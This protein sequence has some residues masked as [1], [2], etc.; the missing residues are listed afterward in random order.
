MVM[1]LWPRFL[2]HPVVTNALD[3]ETVGRPCVRLS[4]LVP[5]PRLAAIL[6]VLQRYRSIAA[7]RFCSSAAAIRSISTAA[8]RSAA[9]A[10]SVTFTA[11]VAS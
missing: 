5:Q 7:R 6:P 9:N 10:S 11:G 1:S 4:R 8:R 2:A 3:Y